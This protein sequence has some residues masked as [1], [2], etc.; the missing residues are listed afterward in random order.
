MR[1]EIHG[2]NALLVITVLYLARGRHGGN[3]SGGRGRRLYDPASEAVMDVAPS[4]A[5]AETAP[6]QWTFSFSCKDVQMP[7]AKS[8]FGQSKDPA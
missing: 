3:G 8:E 5:T 2:N 1:P 7:P 4:A 6:P